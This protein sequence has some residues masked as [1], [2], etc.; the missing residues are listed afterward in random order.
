MIILGFGVGGRA[1]GPLCGRYTL[2]G[3]GRAP[4]GQVRGLPTFVEK[5][6]IRAVE[7]FISEMISFLKLDINMYNRFKDRP[8]QL[9][10][11]R[12]IIFK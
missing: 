8:I 1:I 9:T 2:R 7:R 5:G 4:Q 6:A 12:S 11:M 3:F 10:L